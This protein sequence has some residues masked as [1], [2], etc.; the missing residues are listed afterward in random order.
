M[1]IVLKCDKR[2][3]QRKFYKSFYKLMDTNNRMT[4]SNAESNWMVPKAREVAK[5]G[6]F[7]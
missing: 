7:L 5:N 2:N 1:I 4:D 6:T 3:N